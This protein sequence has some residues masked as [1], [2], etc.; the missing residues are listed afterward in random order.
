M[1]QDAK[2]WVIDT[3]V[4]YEAVNP[5]SKDFFTAQRLLMMVLGRHRLALD[6]DGVILAQYDRCIKRTEREPGNL[7]IWLKQWIQ[8]VRNRDVIHYYD[9]RVPNRHRKALL[10]APL[11]FDKD[12]LA[13]VGVAFRTPDKWLVSEDSDYTP[14]VKKYLT[15]KMGG[16]RVLTVVEAESQV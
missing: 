3:Y 9:G 16:I 5:D 14:A 2:Q 10:S 12:D 6:F 13:F 1:A 4:L 8:R 7:S 11:K 15:E